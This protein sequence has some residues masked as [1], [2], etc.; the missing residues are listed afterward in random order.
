MGACL[1]ETLAGRLSTR[2]PTHPVWPSQPRPAEVSYKAREE[3]E[4]SSENFK[5]E[6]EAFVHQAH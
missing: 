4:S 2:A 5:G 1:P 3:E 6:R